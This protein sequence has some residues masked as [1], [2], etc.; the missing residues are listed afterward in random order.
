[1]TYAEKFAQAVAFLCDLRVRIA[2]TSPLSHEEMAVY[3][4][5]EYT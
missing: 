5:K 3:R 1:M 2:I 4:A